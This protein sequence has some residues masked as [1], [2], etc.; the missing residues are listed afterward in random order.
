MPPDLQSIQLIAVTS[1]FLA[2]GLAEVFIGKFFARE[3]GRED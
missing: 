3:A 2:F 1:I